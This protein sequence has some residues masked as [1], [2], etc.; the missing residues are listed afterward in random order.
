MDLVA[1]GISSNLALGR[2]E[3]SAIGTACPQWLKPIV[4]LGANLVSSAR[5][6]LFRPAALT[7]RDILLCEAG[8]D[9]AEIVGLAQAHGLP[10]ILVGC[11]RQENALREL[12]HRLGATVVSQVRNERQLA[13][14]IARSSPSKPG[15]RVLVL[16]CIGWPNFGD[17]LGFHLLDRVIPPS[18]VVEHVYLPRLPV[19]S[20]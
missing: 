18:A 7:R 3:A 1:G 19:R 10:L 9:A 11:L 17:R 8:N 16:S 14:R 15:G 20:D 6:P 4:P 13:L 5:D 12:L 2:A